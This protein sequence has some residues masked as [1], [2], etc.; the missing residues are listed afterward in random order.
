MA[1][2]TKIGLWK[3]TQFRKVV[4][5]DADVVAMR[6][7]DELFDVDAEFAACPDIGWPDCFNSVGILRTP[8]VGIRVM[9]ICCRV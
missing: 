4:Y 2:L 8:L 6:A 1:A 9:L 5:V 3:Q 7:P